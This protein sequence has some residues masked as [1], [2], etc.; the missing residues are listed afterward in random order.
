MA[1]IFI[2]TEPLGGSPS[3]WAMPPNMN[4]VTDRMRMPWRIATTACASSCSS[5]EAKKRRAVTRAFAQFAAA[6]R[7]GPV[8]GKYPTA[9]VHV[10]SA[11]TRNQ[12]K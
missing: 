6:G 3:I 7:S 1:A 10:R 9:S 8:W 4:K 11:K 2:S 5:I 12:L